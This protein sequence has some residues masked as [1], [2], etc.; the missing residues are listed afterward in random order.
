MYSDETVTTL[1]GRIGFGPDDTIGVDVPE[2]LQTGASGRTYSY[3][4]KLATLRNL[5]ASVEVVN[6]IADDFEAHLDQI[7]ANGVGAALVKVMDQHTSYLDEFD[8][9]S[10]IVLKAPVFD[11]V[12]GYAVAIACIEQ[13]VATTRKNDEERNA[14]LS[15]QRLKIELEGIT[16]ERGFVKAKGITQKYREAIWKAQNVIFPNVLPVQDGKVW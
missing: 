15:Y 8:Y 5:Y 2:T 12:I 9:S 4:H 10:T 11:E 16:D 1:K 6:M 3:F 14:S 7:V 13:M